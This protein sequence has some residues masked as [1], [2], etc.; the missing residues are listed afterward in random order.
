MHLF[1]PCEGFTFPQTRKI[2]EM[3]CE[4]IHQSIP[5][6]TTTAVDI[7]RRGTK[8]YLDPNQNDEADTVA[9]VYSVRPFH[10]PTVSTPLEWKE[11]NGKLNPH[12]YTIKTI[13]KRLEKKGEIFANVLDAK[14]RK[15][16]SKKLRQFL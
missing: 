15:S 4:K 8:L 5:T 11:V 1:I 9:S 3:I 2:A 10:L 6:I 13:W 7:D 14:I 12:D 16:N